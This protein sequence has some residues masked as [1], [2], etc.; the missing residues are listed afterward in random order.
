[1]LKI[2]GEYKKSVVQEK[3][4]LDFKGSSDP[5]HFIFEIN[6]GKSRIRHLTTLNLNEAT[7]NRFWLDLEIQFQSR[8]VSDPTFSDID[9]KNKMAW[10]W[11]TL[12]IS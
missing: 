4:V 8:P 10:V 2:L 12:K 3:T 7:L 1:M 6:V 5:S 11:T 9:F